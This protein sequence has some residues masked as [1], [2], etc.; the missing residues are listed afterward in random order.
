[1]GERI[2]RLGKLAAAYPKTDE[3]L[4]LPT[5][6]DYHEWLVDHLPGEY[7]CSNYESKNDWH[8]VSIVYD[9]VGNNSFGKKKSPKNLPALKL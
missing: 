2:N 8:Y 7:I 6:E 1:M 5:S 3:V 9:S 4:D